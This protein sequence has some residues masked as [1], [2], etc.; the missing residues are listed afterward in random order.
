MNDKKIP[1]AG[2]GK[3]S[4]TVLALAA[5]MLLG[6]TGRGI[7]S[8]KAEPIDLDVKCSLTVKPGDENR[9]DLE[10]LEEKNVVIDLYRVAG[11]KKVPGYD[12]YTFDFEENSPYGSL[13]G[14]LQ[15][16]Q[17]DYRAAAQ[18]AAE[19]TLFSETGSPL[20]PVRSAE[21]GAGIEDLDSGLYLLIARDPELTNTEDYVVRD[22]STR[23]IT[24]I[25]YSDRYTYTFLPELIAL[26]SKE[27]VAMEGDSVVNTAN[28]GPWL[29]DLTVT[30]KPQQ[31]PR[32]G[33]LNIVKNLS[34]YVAGPE[35]AE[36]ASFV[37]QV[38]A[39]TANPQENADAVLVYSDVFE[40][41]F[42]RGGS[43]TI[44]VEGLIPVGSYVI[45]TEVYSGAAYRLEEGQ[46][47]T[48]T[49]L[50]PTPDNPAPDNIATVEFTNVYHGTTTN[51]GAVTN[52]FGYN[53]GGR[54]AGNNEDTGWNWTQQ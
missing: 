15:E 34:E 16:E 6:L 12:T 22:K 53:E 37:F 1:V 20:T 45:V 44:P 38:D 11:A 17:A 36:T 9:E 49:V 10:E 4:L 13:E 7:G 3:R 27:A 54:E 42:D 32:Y 19:I 29:T 21:S 14:I 39:Y 5:C 33:N 31:G 52:H 28:P 46:Q 50:V 30:L 43:K 48:R 18:Q 40:A 51:G 47:G 8:A 35:G 2:K 25:T 41:E 23:E 24:T 26:P